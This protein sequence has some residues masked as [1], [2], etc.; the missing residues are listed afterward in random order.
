MKP[1]PRVRHEPACQ[2]HTVRSLSVESPKVGPMSLLHRIVALG[3]GFI[4]IDSFPEGLTSVK[5]KDCLSGI[6][7]ERKSAK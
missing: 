3:F 7:F 4:L 6:N 5:R 2:C 1:L